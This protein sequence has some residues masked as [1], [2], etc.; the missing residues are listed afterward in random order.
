[1]TN[2]WSDDKA[3]PTLKTTKQNAH[4]RALTV[5]EGI[6]VALYRRWRRRRRCEH[7]GRREEA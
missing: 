4:R 6:A 3:E 2:E 1:M 5:V 7:F